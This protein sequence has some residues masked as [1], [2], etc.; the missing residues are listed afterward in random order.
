MTCVTLGRIVA[1]SRASMVEMTALGRAHPRPP[2][3]RRRETV[4]PLCDS[5]LQVNQ[6]ER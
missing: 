6:S 4:G 3:C 2:Q 1:S 5:A